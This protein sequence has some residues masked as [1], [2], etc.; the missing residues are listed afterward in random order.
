M[1]ENLK[2]QLT[3]EIFEEGFRHSG[4]PTARVKRIDDKRLSEWQRK[5]MAGHLWVQNRTFECC[6]C[7]FVCSH[8]A[9]RLGKPAEK[10]HV[11]EITSHGMNFTTILPNQAHTSNTLLLHVILCMRHLVVAFKFL[12]VLEGFRNGVWTL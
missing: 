8:D 9:V 5:D 2:R 6:M 1:D 4:Q 7:V 12:R 10:P 11:F 3:S